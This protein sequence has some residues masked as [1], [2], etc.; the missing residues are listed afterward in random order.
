LLRVTGDLSLLSLA[1]DI[2]EFAVFVALARSGCTYGVG[3]LFGGELARGRAI[4]AAHDEAHWSTLARDAA[5]PAEAH[6][7]GATEQVQANWQPAAE[8]E[9]HRRRE[10]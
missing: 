1:D 4:A 7:D 5:T 6:P 3:P 9:Y 8:S 10:R 2:D